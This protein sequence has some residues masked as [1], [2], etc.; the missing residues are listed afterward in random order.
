[1]GAVLGYLF[2]YSGNLWLP[3]LYHFVNNASV[4]VITFFCG[5]NNFLEQL[6]KKPLTWGAIPVMIASGV[7]TYFIFTLQ[8]TYR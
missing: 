7:L 1:M 2:L 4:V 6:E 8:E 3:M 5:E